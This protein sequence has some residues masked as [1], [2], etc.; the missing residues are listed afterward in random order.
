MTAAY[1]CL[2]F[3]AILTGL[4]AVSCSKCAPDTG[5]T[6]RP[7]ADMC[8]LELDAQCEALSA[9]LDRFSNKPSRYSAYVVESP[10]AN[11]IANNFRDHQPIVSSQIQVGNNGACLIDAATE[12]SVIVFSLRTIEIGDTAAII[13]ITCVESHRAIAVWD[14]KLQRVGN[15]WIVESSVEQLVT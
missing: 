8:L 14:V 5:A 11:G 13:R 3:V 6:S 15:R 4:T 7:S 10:Y 9:L 2:N 1:R 12:K